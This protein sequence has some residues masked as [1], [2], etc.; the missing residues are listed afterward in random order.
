M[1]LASGRGEVDV[2]KIHSVI[3][4]E[5]APKSVEVNHTIIRRIAM[6]LYPPFLWRGGG[7]LIEIVKTVKHGFGMKPN[8]SDG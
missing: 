5:I 2:L 3:R 8:A 6:L 4:T 7:I 1:V